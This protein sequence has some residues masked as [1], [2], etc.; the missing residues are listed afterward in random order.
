MLYV[1]LGNCDSPCNLPINNTLS[2]AYFHKHFGHF[3]QKIVVLSLQGYL[4]YPRAGKMYFSIE[5]SATNK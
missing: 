5:V 1:S 3:L 2:P 4:T